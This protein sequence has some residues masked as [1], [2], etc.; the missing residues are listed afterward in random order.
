MTLQELIAEI[1]KP[2]ITFNPIRNTDDGSI[3]HFYFEVKIAFKLV[4]GVKPYPDFSYPSEKYRAAEAEMKKNELL[5]ILA[6][7]VQEHKDWYDSTAAKQ[8]VI[9]NFLTNQWGA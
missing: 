5:G 8:G 1:E 7:R 2:I 4:D 9:D 6:E 3:V